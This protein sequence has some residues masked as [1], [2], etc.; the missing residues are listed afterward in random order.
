MLHIPDDTNII[1]IY[2]NMTTNKNKLQK[3][4]LSI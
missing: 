4:I 3:N 1:K 2:L